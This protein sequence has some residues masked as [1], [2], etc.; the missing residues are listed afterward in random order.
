MSTQSDP[1]RI[2]LMFDCL[3]ARQPVGDLF[4]ATMK[5]SELIRITYFDVRRV[6]HEDRYFEQFLGIQRPLEPKR[7]ADLQRY[8]NFLDASFPT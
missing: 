7:V 8:V 5:H 3:R 1:D 2:E 4:V 6:L